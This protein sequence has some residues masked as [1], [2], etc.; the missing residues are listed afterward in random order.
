MWHNHRISK[1]RDITIG[2]EKKL[3]RQQ[4]RQQQQ[5]GW[6]KTSETLGFLDLTLDISIS[7]VYPPFTP[8][9]PAHH[10]QPFRILL[11]LHLLQTLCSTRIVHLVKPF[12]TAP[13]L[14]KLFY[15]PV[16]PPFPS[17]KWIETLIH[18]SALVHPSPSTNSFYGISFFKVSFFMVSFFSLILFSFFPRM[19][20]KASLNSRQLHLVIIWAV[21]RRV[22]K[23]KSHVVT[24]LHFET[25]C[26]FPVQMLFV[27]KYLEA[28]FIKPV[29][30]QLVEI[31]WIRV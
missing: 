4:K 26:I 25:F 28:G 6:E 20:V 30:V 14:V 27:S 2:L 11:R 29:R 15:P 18:Y 31:R 22:S 7:P 16:K 5:H 19:R 24:W 8:Y 3:G 1:K 9:P 17:L 12:Q 23:T 10:Q 13:C 21:Q